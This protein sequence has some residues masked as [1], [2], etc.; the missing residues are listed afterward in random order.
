ME[1]CEGITLFQCVEFNSALPESVA[2]II[3][4]QVQSYIIYV[5][6]RDLYFCLQ[7]FSAISYLHNLSIVHGDIKDENIMVDSQ[8][9]IKL[10]DF[11]W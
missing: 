9:K 11:G 3:S 5:L 10:I 1:R 4:K 8:M 6:Q 2:R 7:V